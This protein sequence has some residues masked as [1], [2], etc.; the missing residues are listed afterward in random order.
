VRFLG[1]CV[2]ASHN[3]ALFSGTPIRVVQCTDFLGI[4]ALS[5]A[6]TYGPEGT[7]LT[8]RI[9]GF[10]ECRTTTT[11]SGRD[12]FGRMGIAPTVGLHPYP[13]STGANRISAKN[14]RT[15]FAIKS[16]TS[17]LFLKAHNRKN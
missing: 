7:R 13:Y 2:N 11:T 8:A 12:P 10:G 6:S 1:L 14:A 5:Q 15:G 3:P 17:G 9:A 16:A 4:F